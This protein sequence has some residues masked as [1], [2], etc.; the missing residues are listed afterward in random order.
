ME[1]NYCGDASKSKRCQ[2]F[3]I[4]GRSDESTGTP[5]ASSYA[6]TQQWNTEGGAEE[7][8]VRRDET[9]RR[10]WWKVMEAAA[11]IPCFNL[12]A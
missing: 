11:R 8:T 2:H 5:K 7:E 10:P 1:R 9:D 4:V 3:V 12:V 6:T